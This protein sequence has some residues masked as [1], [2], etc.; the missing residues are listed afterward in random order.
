MQER[1]EGNDESFYCKE[2]NA[3]IGVVR[4]K[5][6]N[7]A[8]KL[9]SELAKEIEAFEKCFYERLQQ[10]QRN[11]TAP[12]LTSSDKVDE[13]YGEYFNSLI[14]CIRQG[15]TKLR[16]LRGSLNRMEL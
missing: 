16:C 13:D 12:P 4:E 9:H 14:G 3:A 5:A 2:G 8:L 11:V 10:Y 1:Y 7:I 6:S 15:I